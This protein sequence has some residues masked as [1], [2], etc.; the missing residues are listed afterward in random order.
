[1]A[2]TRSTDAGRFR[3]IG[4]GPFQHP[5]GVALPGDVLSMSAEEAARGLDIGRL[6]PHT[7]AAEAPGT[8]E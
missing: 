1:M 7:D 4:D 3:V 6:V 2:R 5:A 8:Q